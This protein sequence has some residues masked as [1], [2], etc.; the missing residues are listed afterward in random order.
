M[1]KWWSFGKKEEKTE[2]Q[3]P[4]K[5]EVPKQIQ[6]TKEEQVKYEEEYWAEFYKKKDE[7]SKKKAEEFKKLVDRQIKLREKLN[8]GKDDN[9]KATLVDVEWGEFTYI[10]RNYQVQKCRTTV[11]RGPN[12]RLWFD[13]LEIYYPESNNEYAAIYMEHLRNGHQ[14][15]TLKDK[16]NILET[17]YF[18]ERHLDRIVKY[19]EEYRSMGGDWKW[20]E[21][22]Q[23]QNGGYNRAKSHKKYKKSKITKHS[24]SMS[25][26][27]KYRSR[28]SK[29]R[30]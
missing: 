10:D 6:R 19:L 17:G 15:L 8:E 30:K 9:N 14:D 1:S 27:R 23:I 25:K 20:R 16:K 21:Q 7:E 24:R 11:R 4:T 18:D 3:P 13:D 29:N 12:D 26:R 22:I 28:K 5:E 2:P